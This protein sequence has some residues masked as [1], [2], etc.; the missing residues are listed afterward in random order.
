MKPGKATAT[1]PIPPRT[2]VTTRITVTN[3]IRSSSS[4]ITTAITTATTTAITTAAVINIKRKDTN[5]QQRAFI[6]SH[7]GQATERRD[8]S[9]G[10]QTS[11]A[12]D[13]QRR[14]AD[15]LTNDDLEA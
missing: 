13:D 6:R 4:V 14:F 15:P 1:S 7:R 3:G 11:S 8:H 10:R 2:G 9:T 12:T 5:P